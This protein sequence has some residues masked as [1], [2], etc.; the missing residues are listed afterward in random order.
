MEPCQIRSR[1]VALQVR[2]REIAD[3]CEVSPPLV[4]AVIHGRR[5][6]QRVE[7]VIA[8][9]LGLDRFEVFGPVGKPG[10]PP[11]RSQGAA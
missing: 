11:K 3:R 4:S 9:L 10:R 8:E 2:N 5:R 7:E 1:L 6:S